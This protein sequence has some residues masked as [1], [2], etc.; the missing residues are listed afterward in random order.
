MAV[1]IKEKT[2][3]ET[4]SELKADPTAV[5]VDVRTPAEWAFIGVPNTPNLHTILWQD[6]PSGQVNPNFTQQVR[7]AGIGEDVPVYL[8]CRSGV[9]SLAAAQALANVGFQNLTNVSDGFEG[10]LDDQ[11]HRN[12]INGW[13]HSN[14]PWRQS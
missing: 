3:N 12:K 6:F 13:R 4:F 11:G 7:E 9:R 8:L 1:E 2:S 5:I 14:L 10:D